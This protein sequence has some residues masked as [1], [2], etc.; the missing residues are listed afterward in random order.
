MVDEQGEGDALF[1]TAAEVLDDDVISVDESAEVLPFRY[2]ITSYGADYPVDGLVKRMETGAIR[3]PAFQRG[4]VWS[5]RQASRFV[6]SLLLGL[7]VPGVFMS[8][9]DDGRGSLLVI[10]GQQRL[11]SLQYFYRGIFGNSGREFRLVG[12]QPAYVGRTY[13]TLDPADQLRLDD[14]IIH[15]TVV[16]QDSPSDDDSS[17]YH[18]FERLN[19]GGTPLSP[20]EIRVAIFHGDFVRLLQELNQVED[21]RRIFGPVS[22]RMR[23]QEL[24]LRFLAF[25]F[26]GAD[27]Y[28]EPMKGFL[29]YF[30]GSNRKLADIQRAQYASAFTDAISLAYSAVGRLAFKPVRALNASVFDAVMVGLSQR[31]ERG[32]VSDRAAV[33][34]AYTRLLLDS[35]FKAATER[36][37]A[38]RDA[39]QTRLELAVT[40]FQEIS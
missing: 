17:I 21:W 15:A 30:M 24:V 11:E 22:R 7:P 1:E 33:S 27:G 26:S 35:E 34:A 3:I 29:N 19:T 9:E 40:A 31:L 16:R 18:V 13:S 23:D 39:V 20:Q 38:S 32:A 28:A 8:R 6:E 25:R 2:S 36:A 14:S 5:Q 12:V 10:D 4:F 37:T